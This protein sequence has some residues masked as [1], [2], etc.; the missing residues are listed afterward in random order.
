[1]PRPTPVA[2]RYAEAAF[3][4]ATRDGTVDRWHADLRAA[5][6]MMADEQVARV[7][8]N[9]SIPLAE[10]EAAIGRL[11]GNRSARPAVNLVRIL[12]RRGRMDALPAVTEHFG[13]LVDESRGIVAATVTSASP[14]SDKDANRVRDRVEA[15]TKSEVRLT[16]EVDPALIGGIIVRVGDKLI[17]ASVRGRLERLREQLVAG[18]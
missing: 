15:I 4:L 8:D 2:R 12:S 16:A 13:R 7:V 18:A 6:E 1:M 3:E 17:D 9:P 14:L 5:T 11:M 10:R